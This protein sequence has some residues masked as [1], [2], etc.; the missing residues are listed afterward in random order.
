MNK[1]DYDMRIW[2]QKMKEEYKHRQERK[3]V[4]QLLK[5]IEPELA[6]MKYEHFENPVMLK[7]ICKLE[8]IIAIGHTLNKFFDKLDD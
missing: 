1:I 5:K 3:D 6:K 4:K 7:K 2:E 8:E